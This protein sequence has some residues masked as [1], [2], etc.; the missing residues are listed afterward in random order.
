M[1]FILTDTLN[2]ELTAKTVKPGVSRSPFTILLSS[3]PGVKGEEE[4]GEFSEDCEEVQLEVVSE[5]LTSDA[6]GVWQMT[7]GPSQP[8]SVGNTHTHHRLYM[9]G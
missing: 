3:V 5:A 8:A 7:S 4:E 6:P 2:T 1:M 9:Y